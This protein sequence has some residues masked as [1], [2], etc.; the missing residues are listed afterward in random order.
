[1]RCAAKKRAVQVC[2]P[3]VGALN[4]VAGG[5]MLGLICGAVW[6]DHA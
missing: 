3:D 1:M 6:F 2:P 5:G 4:D